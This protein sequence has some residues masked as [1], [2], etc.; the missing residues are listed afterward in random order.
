[1]LP[2]YWKNGKVTFQPLDLI[3]RYCISQRNTH[4]LRMQ[5]ILLPFF[6]NVS[7]LCTLHNS[8]HL[9]IRQDIPACSS[10]SVW[11]RKVDLQCLIYK[12][13]IIQSGRVEESGNLVE[14][15]RDP[16]SGNNTLCPGIMEDFSDFGYLPKGL[17]VMDGAI[18]TTHAVLY[19][20]ACALVP[21]K[22][23]LQI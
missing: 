15:T 17:R 6:R 11:R 9:F 14:L 22:H 7:L 4:L 10:H 1:V 21:P 16:L 3:V 12:H 20:L 8:I 18:T 19:D 23:L 2:S 13:L 5:R